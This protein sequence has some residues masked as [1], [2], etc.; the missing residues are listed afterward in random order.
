MNIEI[1]LNAGFCTGV[2]LCIKKLD[3][4]LLEHQELYCIGEVVHNSSVINILKNKGLIIVDNIDEV[5]GNNLVIRAHGEKKETYEKA[6]NK[7]INIYDLTCPKVLNIRTLVKKYLDENTY[8]ILIA[9]KNHPEAIG[10]ISF[11]GR[12][13]CIVETE[14]D[15][16]KIINVIKKYQ[17]ILIIAQ[18]TFNEETF[19]KYTKIIEKNLSNNQNLIIKNTICSAT[20]IRQKEVSRLSKIKECMIIIGGA[21]SSN[22]KKLYEIS[23]SN[24]KNTYLIETKE[25]LDLDKIKEFKEIGIMAGASTPTSIIKEV[26]DLIAKVSKL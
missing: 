25:N 8:I 16:K 3:K 13:S 21:N 12:N 14:E 9:K 18:T 11:C 24:C 5:K 10:T 17:N 6:K 20:S 2:D 4:L 19:K 1:G 7:N 15:I 23:K 22:T 26:Y